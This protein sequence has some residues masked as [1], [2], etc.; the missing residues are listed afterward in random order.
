MA[1]PLPFIL[2]TIILP[3]ALSSEC[4]PSLCPTKCCATKDTCASNQAQCHYCEASVCDTGCCIDNRCAVSA[5][6]CIHSGNK[7]L[8]ICLVASIG[9]LII[10]I[11]VMSKI[12]SKFADRAR[13]NREIEAQEKILVA[14]KIAPIVEVQISP[15]E[16]EIIKEKKEKSLQREEIDNSVFIKHMKK[17]RQA[18]EEFRE[19]IY[20]YY[21]DRG[22]KPKKDEDNGEN[23]EKKEDDYREIILVY[24]F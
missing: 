22:E 23:E 8:L 5:S 12:T 20:H 2:F 13:A 4:I 24:A 15:T 11:L 21:E 14:G 9:A 17:E 16:M 10:L 19:A 1:S 7:T 18:Q 6:D 3:L